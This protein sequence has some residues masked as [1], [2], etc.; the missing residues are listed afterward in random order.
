MKVAILGASAKPGRYSNQAQKLLMKHGHAVFPVSPLGD[1][2]RGVA[3]LTKVPDGMDTVTLYVGE[4]R[5]LPILD[6]IIAAGPLRVIFNPG[7]ESSWAM[8]RL[9]EAG[10]E[11]EEACTLVLL[12]T[13][14]F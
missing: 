1:E 11:S 6:Q 9:T 5:L 10:I 13:G 2:I 8:A 14:S 4:E 12:N 7:T 3:G